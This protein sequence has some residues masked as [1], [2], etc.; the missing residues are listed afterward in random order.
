[1]L[2]VS[3]KG[4][5]GRKLRT[6]LTAL[7]VV[8]GVALI[9]G[10]YILTDTIDRQFDQI[11]A[12]VRK[13]VDVSVTPKKIFNSDNNANPPAFP[14]SYVA[15][16]QQV[17]GVEKAA[18]GIFDNGVILD[19]KGKKIGGSGGAPN[20][21][22]SDAPAPF[23]PFSYVAGHGPT[24]PNQIS[25]DKYTADKQHW[26]VGS[27]VRVGGQGP[28]QPYTVVGIAKFGKLNGLAGAA[29]AVMTLDQAQKVTDKV[30]KLDGIDIQAQKGV[31]P[32]ALVTRVQQS[33]PNTVT[34]RTGAEQAA[35]DSKDTKS[36]LGFI[37]TLLLVF[38]GVALFVGAFMIF[39]SF[40]ITI[41]QRTRELS[42]LRTVGATRRQVLGSV[43]GEAVVMG[44]TASVIGLGL[45]I[46]LAKG[47]K[48]LFKAVGADLPG[49]S[50]VVE[51]RT[52]IVSLIV[53]TLVTV[54]ASLS[55]ALRATRIQPIEGV[56][57]GAVMPRTRFSRIKTP[58]GAVTLAL[59][60][61]LMC[62]GLLTNST[63]SGVWLPLLFGTV[64]VFIGAAM[65]SSKLVRPIASLVGRPMESL[66]G[67]SGQL[68]RE[69]ATRNTS[70]TASTAAAL[71]IGLA[72]V[73]GVTIFAAG[74]KKSVDSAID[75]S[76]RAGLILENKDGWS[77]IPQ[78]AGKAVAQVPGVGA[79]S[80]VRLSQAK[81]AGVSGT[82]D[83]S[84]VNPQTL[85]A[86][87]QLDWKKGSN[88][89]LN[90]LSGNNAIVSESWSKSKHKKV[91]QQISITTQSGNHATYTI[92]GT[93]KNNVHF[94]GDIAVTNQTL[95]RDFKVTQDQF[96][97]YGLKPGAN[98]NQVQ[99][100]ATK[101]LNAQFPNAQADTKSGF[102][103]KQTEWISQISAF[104]YVLLSL[105]VIV[106]LFGIVNTL[107]L[108]IYERT[109]ELGLL[110][111]VGMSKRQVKRI[112]RYESVITALIG[113][114][115]GTVLGVFF[116][117]I[118]SRPLAGE[119]FKLSFPVGTLVILLI[120]AGLAG[121]LAAITPARRASKLNVLEAL[122]YE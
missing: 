75:T 109:R 77:S 4:M 51:S 18:G 31:S 95:A 44:F 28:A 8:L 110:R 5:A 61:G 15:Q 73:S 60:V 63:G 66:R 96:V 49:G 84:G 90:Q 2:A 12:Q 67:V 107:V 68:A 22:S 52:I 83:V 98:E 3:L 13:G 116:A 45:G 40:S 115:L 37:K 69:N 27:V 87:Y 78:S 82:P 121:V 46:V 89:T 19:N 48:A 81:V 7:A 97:M 6:V 105:A 62:L 41:A 102:K 53:G 30:G 113:A 36:G 119:G 112:V 103:K 106:S 86:V 104:F 79:S 50:A 99:A 101:I 47:L 54:I 9:A 20:F 26:H 58:F 91:G 24:G 117:V 32:Q 65:F 55:P 93:Y 34:V 33:L 80:E 71:M 17:P 42:M 88:A 94:L 76:V 21:I 43:L 74:I 11:F 10:T 120:L 111:A 118:V 23:N 29:I 38:A 57:E 122:A 1:M 72:L 35:Q 25:I 70:R 59:G 100:Q 64:L 108:A 114:I 39:N 92:I 14:A 85:P 16:V 56:R